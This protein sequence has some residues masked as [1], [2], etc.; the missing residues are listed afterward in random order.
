MLQLL[1]SQSG[2]KLGEAC[3]EPSGMPVG[4]LLPQSGLIDTWA[5]ARYVDVLNSSGDSSDRALPLPN[6]HASHEPCQWN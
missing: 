4:D 3:G 5:K 1:K 6:A 2:P